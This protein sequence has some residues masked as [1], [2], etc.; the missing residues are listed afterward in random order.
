MAG[1]NPYLTAP[2]APVATRPFSIVVVGDDGE[3]RVDVDPSTLPND[4]P[5]LPGSVLSILLAA[6]LDVEHACGG[7]CACSTCHVYVEAGGAR[8]NEANDDEADMLDTAPALRATSRLA[9]QCVPDG[10][11]DLRVRIP[12]WNRNAVREHG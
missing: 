3:L 10:G 6:G 7:V 9:C 8:C 11:A 2:D 1:R 4:E 12:R 5:G